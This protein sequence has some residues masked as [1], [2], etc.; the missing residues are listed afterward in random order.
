MA[1]KPGRVGQLDRTAGALSAGI[2]TERWFALPLES[3][4]GLLAAAYAER[5]DFLAKEA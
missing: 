5:F 3:N 4:E 1:E 2:R